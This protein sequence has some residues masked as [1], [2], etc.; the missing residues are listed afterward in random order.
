MSA[1]LYIALLFQ[2]APLPAAH[3]SGTLHT[4]TSKRITVSTDEGNE[5]EFTI[6][7]KTKTER[8]GK[9]ISVQTLQP[10]E[11]VTVDAEQE[12]LGYLIALKVSAAASSR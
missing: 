3:F 7:R 11:P 10:G 6:T 12:L 4:V 5:V 8:G 2:S 1:L 9:S